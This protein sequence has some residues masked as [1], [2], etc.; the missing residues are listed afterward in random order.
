MPDLSS[1]PL[2][3]AATDADGDGLARL[4]HDC[5]KAYPGCVFDRAAEM[6]ELDAIASH[7]ERQGG[8][9][10]IAEA[11]ARVV[12]SLGIRPVVDGGVELLKV[13]VDESHRGSGLAVA[14][15]DRALAFAHGRDATRIELWS[16]TRFTRGHGFYKKH[17][18]VATGESRFLADL[19]D[20][21]EF[22]FVRTLEPGR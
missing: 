16:D 10:W 12:G 14:L 7:F 5:F 4:I 2:V 9:I 13:Y 15:L 17:G 1:R 3:R 19:S 21:W 11:A 8:R 6:P 18:F 20:T 22:Q